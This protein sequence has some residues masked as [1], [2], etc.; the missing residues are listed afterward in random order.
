MISAHGTTN[1]QQVVLIL[2]SYVHIQHNIL[3]V[4]PKQFYTR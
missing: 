2:V 4:T 3:L 1:L